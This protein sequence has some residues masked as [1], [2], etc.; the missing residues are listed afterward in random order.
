MAML[1]RNRNNYGFTLIELMIAMVIA[2]IVAA[3]ILMSF[4][5]QQKT[6][7][8]QQLI[9][10]MQQDARAALYLMQQDIRMAGYDETWEDTN[11]DGVDDNRPS[12]GIDNDCDVP[13]GGAIDDPA[14]TDEGNDLAGIVQAGPNLIQIRMDENRDGNFCG[15]NDLIT[16]AL[17]SGTGMGT[18]DADGMADSGAMELRRGDQVGG[19]LEPLAGSIQAIAFGYAFDDDGGAPDGLVDTDAGGNIIWA[20]DNNA[21]GFLDTLLDSNADGVIDASDT[22]TLMAS[23]VPINRIRAVRIWILGRTRLPLRDHHRTETF[24][25]G[26]KII[27]QAD[28]YE[29]VLL[30]TTVN[31]RNL[32]LR[33]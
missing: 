13:S 33:L 3:A 6:Q 11:T 31:C 20:Y 15:V 27:T 16:Y 22:P 10:D 23:T 25:V 9:V 18:I 1:K 14:D 29:R 26:D 17:A 2:G 4:D 5:S 32:G 30:T 7:V 21:D 28:D 12:D 24:V 8:N 19:N